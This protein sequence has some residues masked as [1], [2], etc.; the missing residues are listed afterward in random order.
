MNYK[1]WGVP[2]EFLKSRSYI[3]LRDALAGF[4]NS[5]LVQLGSNA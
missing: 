1:I 5:S 3:L 4:R 2:R